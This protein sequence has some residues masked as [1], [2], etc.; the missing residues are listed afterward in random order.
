MQ[1]FLICFQNILHLVSIAIELHDLFR[2]VLSMSIVILKS[3][4]LIRISIIRIY[5]ERKNGVILT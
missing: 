2:S 5:T 1:I 3:V 4:L